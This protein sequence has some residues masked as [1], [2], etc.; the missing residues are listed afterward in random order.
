GQNR[1]SPENGCSQVGHRLARR[2]FL[3]GAGPGDCGAGVRGAVA[4]GRG[5]TPV[6]GGWGGAPARTRA[7][8]VPGAPP[9]RRG[10]TPAAG[11]GP[12]PRRSSVVEEDG[13]VP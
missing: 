9:P 10:R 3:A 11:R 6:A 8:L 2:C 4:P 1:A 7:P 5:P 13:R 12:P